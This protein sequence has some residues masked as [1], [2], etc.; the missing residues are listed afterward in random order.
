MKNKNKIAKT[1]QKIDL[2][3]FAKSWK[4]PK[5]I[6]SVTE[7]ELK[8]LKINKHIIL[9]LF[10]LLIPN[11]LLETANAPSSD[12]LLVELKSNIKV[13]YQKHFF[14]KFKLRDF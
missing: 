7:W 10:L 5:I 12:G 9:I 4:K 1:H 6:P 11:M 13:S 8:N 14:K 2:S 3:R